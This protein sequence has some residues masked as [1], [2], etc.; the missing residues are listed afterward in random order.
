MPRKGDRKR[1]REGALKHC[2]ERLPERYE[3]D[4]SLE[5]IERIGGMVRRQESRILRKISQKRSEREVSIE[6]INYRFI[7]L[8]KHGGIIVTFLP[9]RE[10]V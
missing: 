2:A 10:G 9:P 1:S 7:Y 5:L 4:F 6:G 8:N 3:Q